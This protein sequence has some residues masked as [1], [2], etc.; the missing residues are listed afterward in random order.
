MYVV[1][2]TRGAKL[3]VSKH[4]TFEAAVKALRA[5]KTH[6]LSHEV[7]TTDA[8]TFTEAYEAQSAGATRKR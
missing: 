8:A 3:V 1:R 6:A 5:A 2:E 4:D 7:S